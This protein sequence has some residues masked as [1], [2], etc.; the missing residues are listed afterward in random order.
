MER[1][2]L[3]FD[4]MCRKIQTGKSTERVVVEWS[5]EQPQLFLI[6]FYRRKPK[7]SHPAA[8]NESFGPNR[9]VFVHGLTQQFR[10]PR[11]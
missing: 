4:W 10:I 6:D 11:A 2:R 5:A 9:W 1:Q 8:A 3:D 7:T